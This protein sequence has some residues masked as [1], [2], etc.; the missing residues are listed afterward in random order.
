[1]AYIEADGIP[2]HGEGAIM[3]EGLAYEEAAKIAGLTWTTHTEKMVT[4]S[5][6]PVPNRL[7]VVR[8][9]DDLPIG[10]ERVLGDVT[11]RYVTVP[12]LEVLDFGNGIVADGL[13]DWRT[14]GSLRGGK[15]IWGLMKMRD[16]WKVLDDIHETYIAITA[17]YDGGLS[18]CATPTSVRIVCAN[19]HR[20]VFGERGD[21]AA[22]RIRH[23]RSVREKMAEAQKMMHLTTQQQ[24]NYAAWL[25]TIAAEKVEA[26]A[27]ND[28]LVEMFGSPEDSETN[29]I[30]RGLERTLET[31][32]TD[33]LM[34]EVMRGGETAYSV[35]QALTGYADHGFRYNGKGTNEA[36][37]DQRKTEARFESNVINGRSLTFKAKATNLVGLLTGTVAA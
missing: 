36:V 29:R 33:Y 28:L 1:M 2:W 31:F 4:V 11:G 15:V 21:T 23:S 32:R 3:P 37:K 5:G 35:L 13:A 20:M 8:D 30:A 22:I 27:V 14:L 34:P 7:A 18:I 17:G 16:D 9:G 19:T 24:R 26:A 6:H 25:E 12:P 10:A